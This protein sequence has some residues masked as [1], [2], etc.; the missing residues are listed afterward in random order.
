MVRPPFLSPALDRTGA[1]YSRVHLG[2]VSA[3][4]EGYVEAWRPASSSLCGRPGGVSQDCIC[5]LFSNSRCRPHGAWCPT[6]RH[7]AGGLSWLLSWLYDH[8]WKPGL[9]RNPPAPCQAAI[10]SDAVLQISEIRIAATLP[11]SAWSIRGC[12]L[13]RPSGDSIPGISALPWTP[14][15]QAGISRSGPVQARWGLSPGAKF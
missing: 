9:H 8:L 7:S 5:P 15:T 13:D 14:T 11:A 6:T 1:K 2:T 3:C 10:R 12:C 4:S